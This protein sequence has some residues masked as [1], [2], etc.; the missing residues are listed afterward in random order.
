[1][2]WNTCP[3]QSGIF[4]AN[5]GAMKEEEEEEEEEERWGKRRE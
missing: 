1:L 5:E 2:R 4:F 3:S